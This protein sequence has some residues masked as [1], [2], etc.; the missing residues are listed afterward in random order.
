ML[1]IKTSSAG[2]FLLLLLTL[3]VFHIDYISLGNIGNVKNSVP[4]ETFSKFKLSN[5]FEL[6][7]LSSVPT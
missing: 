7:F 1:T 2:V 3:D 4:M 6:L 5:M